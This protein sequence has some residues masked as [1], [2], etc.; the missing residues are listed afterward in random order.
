M[1]EEKLQYRTIMNLTLQAFLAFLKSF[2]ATNGLMVGVDK[3]KGTQVER[4]VE[5]CVV[6]ARTVIVCCCY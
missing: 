1:I 4:E 6:D 2:G 5:R 3:D